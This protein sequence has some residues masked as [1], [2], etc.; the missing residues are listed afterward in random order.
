MAL[1]NPQSPRVPTH[2]YVLVFAVAIIT[3]LGVSIYNTRFAQAL[4]SSSETASQISASD[5]FAKAVDEGVERALQSDNTEIDLDTLLSKSTLLQNLINQAVNERL[6]DYGNSTDF[7]DS[8]SLALPPVNELENNASLLKQI[9]SKM[10][11]YETK[12]AQV[13]RRVNDD[14]SVQAVNDLQSNFVELQQ[15][16]GGLSREVRCSLAMVGGGKSSF[17]LKEKR[18]TELQMYKIIVTLGALK[19]DLI[20]SV[21]ISGPN[22]DST[23]ANTRV[24]ANVRLGS[25][26]DFQSGGN[27]YKG[28][29]TFRQARFGPDF[30]GFEVQETLIPTEDCLSGE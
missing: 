17:L 1:Q 12:L 18:S 29:F 21:T 25:A 16:I 20:E 13:T 27:S 10:K 30:V 6:I 22:A 14:E 15:L 9:Q 2:I 28:V 11:Q 5:S 19:K 23:Q 26:I 3:A 7:R 4:V 24:I 8:V